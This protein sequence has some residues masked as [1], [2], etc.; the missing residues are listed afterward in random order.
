MLAIVT[1]YYNP[2]RRTTKEQ[3]YRKFRESLNHPVFVVELAFGDD[4]FTLPLGE[5]F[6]QLRSKD[7]LW[8]QYRLLNVVIKN[9]PDCYDQVAWIDADILFDD[10]DWHHKMQESLQQYKFVQSFSHVVLQERNSSRGE[11]KEG[12][13]YRAIQNSLK[14][15]A[16]TLSGNLDLSAKF[17]SGFSWGVQRETIEKFG[18][19]DYWITGSCD[20]AFALGIWGDWKNPFLK[21]R[22]NEAMLE[23]YLEWAKPFH[24]FVSG[25]VNYLDVQIRH[26]WHGSRNYRKR[27]ACLKSLDPYQDLRIGSNDLLEWNSNKPDMHQCCRNMCL[28]YDIE[29]SPYL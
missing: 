18:I 5:C 20:T 21:K 27:W 8:Q 23:H 17:A 19:Y 9:L 28:N 14:P 22:L 13:A 7:V 29:Y 24:A 26:L 11:T 2:A 12:I 4:P 10:P 16:T 3:N 6:L 25:S 15:T 1:N